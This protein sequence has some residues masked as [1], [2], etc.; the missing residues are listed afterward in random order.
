MCASVIE[1]RSS[2]CIQESKYI[3]VYVIVHEH[4]EQIHKS[5]CGMLVITKNEELE[6]HYCK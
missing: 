3:S 1:P 5:N 2:H 4:Y 6:V